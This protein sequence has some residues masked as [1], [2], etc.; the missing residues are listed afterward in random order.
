[1]KGAF[2]IKCVM[3][4]GSENTTS[5]IWQH[6]SLGTIKDRI[7]QYCPYYREKFEIWD[8]PYF[9]YYDDGRDIMLRF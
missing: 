5:D 3:P 8:G 9:N 6:T 7:V 4:D 1:M 2:R